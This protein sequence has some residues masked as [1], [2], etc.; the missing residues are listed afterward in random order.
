MRKPATHTHL[1]QVREIFLAVH[2]ELGGLVVPVDAEWQVPPRAVTHK[3]KQKT[4]TQART[5]KMN[6]FLSQYTKKTYYANAKG[7]EPKTRTE[8]M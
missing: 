3:H 8:A 5:N 4:Q 6:G 1:R 7:G 2:A